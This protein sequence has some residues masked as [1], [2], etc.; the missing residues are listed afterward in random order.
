MNRQQ[1]GFNNTCPFAGSQVSTPQP[2]DLRRLM[3][4]V[5]TNGPPAAPASSL[6]CPGSSRL[7][8]NLN[9]APVVNNPML[10][11]SSSNSSRGFNET[12]YEPSQQ[13]QSNRANQR[14][15]VYQNMVHD[16]YTRLWLEQQNRLEH[17]RRHL[18]RRLFL[19]DFFYDF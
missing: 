15:S 18:M 7:T 14:S 16:N 17:Q 2:L 13:Q 1:H 11:S 8:S 10:S 9:H 4:P 3:T 19:T 12:T 5:G 6:M